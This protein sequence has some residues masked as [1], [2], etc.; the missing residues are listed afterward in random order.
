MAKKKKYRYSLDTNAWMSTYTDLMTLLLTF[1]VLLLSL[2]TVDKKKKRLALNSLVGAFG[3]KPGGQS[4]L[5]TQKGL[6]ITTSSSPLVEEDV[7]FERLRNVA[8]KHGLESELTMTKQLDRTIITLKNK[9]LFD[10]NSS[11][12]MTE[13]SEFLSEL[14]GVLKEG[15]QMIELRGYCDS[16]ESILEEDPYKYSMILSSKRAIAMFDFLVEKGLS[17][18]DIVAHGFGL[19]Y[20]DASKQPSLNRQVEIIL[21]YREKVPFR[22]RK[23]N[24]KGGFLDFKGFFFRTARDLNDRK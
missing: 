13:N 14:A 11:E 10:H 3:F 17:A 16:S 18:G 15:H 21:D 6:N 22:M 2:S 5:G 8:L 20:S 9:V 23:Q 24:E 7:Q 12:L 1:F 4:I 19:N